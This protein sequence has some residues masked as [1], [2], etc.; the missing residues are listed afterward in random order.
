M[1]S[2][3]RR[4]LNAAPPWSFIFHIVQGRVLEATVRDM[5]LV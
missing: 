1:E 5:S 3:T 4:D 2:E